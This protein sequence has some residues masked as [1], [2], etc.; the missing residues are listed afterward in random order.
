M[1]GHLDQFLALDQLT[2]AERLNCACDKLAGLALDDSLSSGDVI[3]RLL[4]G[5]DLVVLLDGS[6][7]TG[8]LERT[9]TRSWGDKQARWH[10]HKH[11]IIPAHL[12]DSVYWDGVEKV[13]GGCSEMFS[14]W[15]S[16]QVSGFNGN[17]HL[18]RY[19]DGRTVDECP[20][21]GCRPER[22]THMIYCRDPARSEVYS[23]S[24][25]KLVT[26][27][28]GQNTDPELT[29][30][31]SAYLR[32][33]GDHSMLS[34]CRPY[35]RYC[36]LADMVDNLGLRNLLEG[37]I[38]RLF[39]DCRLA[40]IQRRGLRKHAGHW[41][42]GLILRLLQITH[43]Q[44]TFRCGTVHLRGPDGLTSSQRDRLAQRCEDLLWTDPS[45]LLEDD[46]YLLA[47]DFEDIGAAPSDTRQ[48]W[49]SEMEAARCAATYVPGSLDEDMTD[50]LPVPIDSEGS[51]RF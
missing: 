3:S 16:K 5:E 4:P 47:L 34:L 46:R 14:V 17:N 48:A 15:A 32:G 11:N 49:I 12:F 20:N 19:I 33:R 1:H 27:L 51:I 23:S 28:A 38:P 8:D 36:Q 30:L 7:A 13:L 31:L 35:S 44:W 10:Y 37:R 22:S 39:Y 18:Q 45:T 25:D 41:C 26:W 40:D 9:I 21:C 42:N 50:D 24:V 6:K 2:P 43:R 29:A